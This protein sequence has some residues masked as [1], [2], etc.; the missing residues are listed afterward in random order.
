MAWAWNALGETPGKSFKSPNPLCSLWVLAMEM[1]EFPCVPFEFGDGKV[2]RFSGDDS[3]GSQ[4]SGARRLAQRCCGMGICRR[5]KDWNNRNL[6]QLLCAAKR[7]SQG[8][9]VASVSRPVLGRKL[10]TKPLCF[11]SSQSLAEATAPA[12]RDAR[13]R[14]VEEAGTRTKNASQIQRPPSHL[15]K[16]VL[17]P[18][19]LAADRTWSD[20]PPSEE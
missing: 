17:G 19:P 1:L 10:E 14:S 20:V 15:V 18:F 4:H 13:Q 2:H 3:E 6:A 11:I 16:L 7:L 12:P 5:A 9:G 8:A